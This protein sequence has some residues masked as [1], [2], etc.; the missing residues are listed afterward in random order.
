[1][2]IV[3]VKDQVVYYNINDDGNKT[4]YPDN[5]IGDKPLE[6]CQFVSSDQAYAFYKDYGK[7]A[8]FDVRKGGHYK[9]KPGEDPNLKWLVA[10]DVEHSLLVDV[11]HSLLVDVDKDASEMVDVEYSLLVEVEHSVD[12]LKIGGR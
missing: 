1:V 8:G 11:E 7:R 6:G 10:D 2:Q 4:W 3:Y 12:M 5:D 9:P